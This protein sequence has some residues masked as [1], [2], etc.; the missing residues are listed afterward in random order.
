MSC[1]DKLLL[2]MYSD[3]ELDALWKARIETHMAMCPTC[4]ARVAR[5]GKLSASV[6]SIDAQYESEALA[7]IARLPFDPEAFAAARRKKAM[8]IDIP[9]LDFIRSLWQRSI[10][11]PLPV[12][13]AGG[14]AIVAAGFLLAGGGTFSGNSS[15]QFPSMA[16]DPSMS[17]I[18][19]TENASLRGASL[20]DLVN[21]VGTQQGASVMTIVLP[22]GTTIHTSSAEPVL[23]TASS[24]G[25]GSP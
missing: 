10:D 23:M 18:S 6:L 12:V 14:L 9:V 17:V 7:R 1:P 25:G 8:E 13:A 21:S 22:A 24:A 16:R 2:S 11:L 3:G 5:Y 15:R 4:S 19:S 20:A